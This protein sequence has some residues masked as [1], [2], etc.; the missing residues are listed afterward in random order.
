M[1]FGSPNLERLGNRVNVPIRAFEDAD[2]GRECPVETCR[3]NFKITFGAGLKGPG[4]AI[5]PTVAI[6]APSWI[7][8]R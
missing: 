7:A 4:P 2:V 3:G 8:I 6:V 1:N 5:A